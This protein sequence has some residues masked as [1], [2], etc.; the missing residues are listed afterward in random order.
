[1]VVV[2]TYNRTINRVVD[3]IILL[4]FGTDI[5]S[6]RAEAAA[7]RQKATNATGLAACPIRAH[8]AVS[9]NN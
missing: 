8:H 2:T 3:Y 4:E 7:Q 5:V 9:S 6:H 1:M